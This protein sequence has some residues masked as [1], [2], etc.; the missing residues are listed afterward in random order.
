V[1]AIDSDPVV[2]GET[3]LVAR[4]RDLDVLPL[5]VNLARPTPAIGWRNDECQS[6]LERTSGR[7]DF[8]LMLAII[9]HMLVTERVPL[10]EILDLAAQLTTNYLLIEFIEP[11]DSMFRRLTRG[12]DS[13]FSELTVEAFEGCCRRSFEIIR[14]Q[15]ADYSTRWLYL[16]QRRKPTSQDHV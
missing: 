11:T 4:K 1:V 16:L 5:V 10:A 8:V 9:H 14:V 2:V 7:F 3:W 12:R 15:H 6:F 13:L